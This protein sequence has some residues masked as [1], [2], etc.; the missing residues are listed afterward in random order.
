MFHKDGDDD[1]DEHELRDENEDDEVDRSDDR[2]DAA[3]VYTVRR[4]VTV[5]AQCVLLQTTKQ[6]SP[7]VADKPARRLRK[8]RT[9][10]VRAVGL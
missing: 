4:R 6:E 1:V 5:V 3:V 9:V 2:I 8:V 10:Y 7:A